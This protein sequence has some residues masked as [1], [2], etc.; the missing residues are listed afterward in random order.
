MLCTPF[1]LYINSILLITIMLAKYSTEKALLCTILMGI[2]IIGILTVSD[3]GITYD[4]PMEID[5]VKWHFD[6]ATSNIDYPVPLIRYY[7]IVFNGFC[8]LIYSVAA[9]FNLVVHDTS[10]HILVSKIQIKHVLTF[11]WTFSIYFFVT[12]IVRIITSPQPPAKKRPEAVDS[13]VSNFKLGYWIT[14]IVLSL[15]PRFWGHG[16]FN[17]KDI[18]FAVLFTLVTLIG[19]KLVGLYLDTSAQ[20]SQLARKSVAYGTLVGILGGIRPI[21]IISLLFFGLT[22]I[23]VVEKQ[24]GWRKIIFRLIPYYM[25]AIFTCF[26][27]L[28]ILYPSAWK[29]P[30]SWLISSFT[31]LS[32]YPW[33]GHV[34]FSGNYILSTSLPWSYIPKYILVSTP[35]II[36][37]ISLL[38]IILAV[39][40]YK[41]FSVIQKSA[42]VLIG[43][44]TFTLPMLAIINQSTLY[45]EIRHFLFIV[46]GMAVYGSTALIWLSRLEVKSIARVSLFSILIVSLTSILIDT[47]RLHPYEYTYFNHLSGRLA[48]AQYQYESDYWGLSF[49]ESAQWLNSNVPKQSQKVAILGP[50]LSA[51]PFLRSDFQIVGAQYNE[52]IVSSIRTKT[53]AHL[54]KE[55]ISSAYSFPATKTNVKEDIYIIALRRWELNNVFSECP[56]LHEVKRDGATLSVIRKCIL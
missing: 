53:R 28:F 38:G 9:S 5:M 29:N 27:T 17:P 13:K 49:K 55:M 30:F 8:E 3:Y 31:V 11:F 40:K 21:G 23:L 26:L 54:F 25:A 12:D 47:Y 4:E 42:F 41:N 48:S 34:L 50:G 6:Y 56:I 37:L 52:K 19:T 51:L 18:P 35:E 32:K 33:Y 36:I 10:L 45:D 1:L 24:I 44:Q 16:F 20:P 14:P 15:F 22:C 2:F 43:F 46:P 7:G 39:I